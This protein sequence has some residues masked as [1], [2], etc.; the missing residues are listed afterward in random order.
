MST[1]KPTTTKDWSASQYL[2]FAD[3]R[4]LPARELLARVPLEAPKTIVDLGCG[5]GNSTAVLAARYPGAHIVGLDS[6]PDMIQ[7]AKSTLP[8]IDFRVADLRSYTPS[9]PT[10]LFFSNAVLQWLRRDERI[11]VVK[12]LLRTQS[13]GGVFAFQVP[14]NLMEPSHVLMRDVAA[15]GPWAETLTHVHRDGIQ[16]PQEIYDELIPLCATVSIFHT[17][18][19]HSLE[20]HEAIVEWLKGTGLRP[21]VDPLGPAEKKAFI[22]EYLKR[23][24]GAYPRSVD[25][26]VL[27]RFPRLFVVAVRK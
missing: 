12:R 3:E 19:Y 6:S 13:P 17:H 4:T 18:Y 1:A 2:K 16:S 23:L 9:S 22:A 14:D 5:P 15:R 26:R 11:E 10:D 8:E 7:K 24:E 25:G 21:Y 27:L 20:N